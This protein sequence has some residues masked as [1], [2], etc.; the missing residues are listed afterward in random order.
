[1][2]SDGVRLAKATK[3][4]WIDHKICA[5]ECVVNKYRLYFQHLQHAITNIKVTHMWKRWGKPQN[6]VLAF[7]DELEE[8][9]L[10]KLLKWASKKQNNF[11]VYN[12]P[13]KKKNKEK[14]L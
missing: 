3:I 6:F 8:Q 7:I 9:L 13:F 2:H 12:V 10:K 1:M 11:N 5:M 14:H 4:R